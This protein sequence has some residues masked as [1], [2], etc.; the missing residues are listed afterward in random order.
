MWVR[1]AI[2]GGYALELAIQW[3]ALTYFTENI[4]PAVGNV[5]GLAINQHDNDG[6]GHQATIQ[7]AAVLKDSVWCTPKYFGTVKFLADHKLQFIPTN[8][9]TGVT[10]PI[11]YDGSSYPPSTRK[12]GDV[13]GNGVDPGD[14]TSILRICV[15]LDTE[16]APGTDAFYG[17]DANADGTISPVDASWVL[18]YLVNDEYPNHTLPKISGTGGV[19]FAKATATTDENKDQVIE[20]P[21][22]LSKSS[23]VISAFV[24]INIDNSIAD[25]KYVKAKLPEG[26]SMLYNYKNSV[27]KIA[28]AGIHEL[29]NGNLVNIGIHLKNKET[30]LEVSGFSQLNDNEKVRLENTSV[31]EIPTSFALQNN[32]PNPFNPTTT[33]KYQIPENAHVRLV[34]YNMLGQRVRTI[35]DQPQEAGY[36]SVQWDGRNDYGESVSSGIYVYRI[37]AGSFITSKKMNLIK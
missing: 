4:T 33:I 10:N 3:S 21:L 17:A 35:V 2:P 28:I 26:S 36:Y 15:G 19:S 8:N 20:L 5:F 30:K 9:M 34:V 12:R 37:K 6:R 27:L 22:V 25:V 16:P 11:P 31:R 13:N 18:Y 1:K 14:A 29:A 24:N 23:G 7:W 32:Y